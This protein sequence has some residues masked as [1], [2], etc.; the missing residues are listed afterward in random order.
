MSSI[1]GSGVEAGSLSGL[2]A[3]H[4]GII[5]ALM[6]SQGGLGGLLG[7]LRKGGLSG[8]VA[9]WIGTGANQP[10]TGE[11]VHAALPPEVVNQMA[12]KLGIEPMQ[13]SHGLAQVLPGLVDNLSPSGSLPQGSALH[14]ALG[15]L[16][17]T[18]LGKK[19]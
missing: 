5:Q 3:R 13:V 8:A 12:G 4:A 18:I 16:L 7:H 2:G 6:E 14:G 19:G 10:V 11:Q 9:S 17:G 15:G 1:E